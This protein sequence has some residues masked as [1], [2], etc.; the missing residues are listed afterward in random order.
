LHKSG[1]SSLTIVELDLWK[2]LQLFF[3]V[4]LKIL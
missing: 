2:E 1:L 3:Y 4:L